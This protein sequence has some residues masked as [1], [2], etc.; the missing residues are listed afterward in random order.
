MANVTEV[1]Q[2]SAWAGGVKRSKSEQL[3]DAFAFQC[4]AR[5]LPAFVTEHRFAKERGRQ[6]RFDFCWPEYR[7]AVELDGL[8]VRKIGRETVTM[9]RHATITG[10]RQDMV[11]G[12]LA[13]ELGWFVLHF[14]QGMVKSGAAID[15]TLAVLY[16]RGFTR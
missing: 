8:V 14:E 2:A 4:R 1:L 12:N 10:M 15:T 6:F 13:C 11:K 16:A 7:V 5:R 9:G 3:H